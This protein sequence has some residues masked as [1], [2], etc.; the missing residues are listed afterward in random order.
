MKFFLDTAN[1]DEIRE[2]A[3]W[4]I[5]DGVTTNPSLVAKEGKDF[6][7]VIREIQDI[8]K[9]P[10]NAEVISME[11][12]GMMREA[13]E[14]AAWGEHVIV[15]VPMCAE[16]L[17]TISKCRDEGIRTNVTLIFSVNQALLAA[18]AGA[19]YVS[20]FLGRLDD[21]SHDGLELIADLVEVF[22]NYPELETEI[23]AASIRHPLHV[24]ECARAG[25]DIATVPMKVLQM[26]V[27]HPLTDKGIE[28]FLKDWEKVRAT[29][30]ASRAAA[31]S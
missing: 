2:A 30:P 19:S 13:R 11:H 26:M 16:G 4:G 12:A 15:K 6:K 18:K 3:S 24:I 31:V 27:K 7:A 28:T 9:G 29:A 1:V 5:L 23:L 14:Y 17:K 21:I 25:A 20:P 10:V 22:S 8:V